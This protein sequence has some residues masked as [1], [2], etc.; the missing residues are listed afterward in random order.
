MKNLQETSQLP[1]HEKDE[2]MWKFILK[3]KQ[4]NF[5]ICAYLLST[6]LA[7]L[8]YVTGGTH[9]S[10]VSFMSIPIIMASSTNRLGMGLIH[11][12]I[13]G[14][15]VGPFMPLLTASATPQEPMNWIIRTCYFLTLSL[16]TGFFADYY[17]QVYAKYHKIEK[18]VS[19]AHVA[20]I[21]ALTKLSESRDDETG[22]HI[23]RV[24]E[25]CKIL[26]EKLRQNKIFT[27]YITD[28]YIDNL[29]KAS[30][31]H[32]IGKVGIPDN[33]LLKPG[34]LTPEEFNIIK[35]H[36]TIGSNI[37]AEIQAKYPN[38]KFLALGYNIVHYHHEKWDGSGYPNGLAK[39][40]IPLSAR[41]M[42]LVDVYDALRSKRVYKDA[43]SHEKC[44]DIIKQGR[45]SHFDPMLVDVFL[46]NEVLFRKTFDQITERVN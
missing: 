30:A 9:T 39:D 11:A 36:P 23:E 28:N 14:L 26:A 18:E 40:K 27:D 25:L 4:T 42:A 6:L 5:L 24:S 17:K 33:I 19:E 32:D 20:T 31:L 12:G 41:I 1:F 46:E 38:N 37:L 43:Y 35:Q 21:Y 8:V 34:K 45:G 2:V 15:M 3:I 13:S 7:I 22:A 16:V 29:S 44:L 10:V